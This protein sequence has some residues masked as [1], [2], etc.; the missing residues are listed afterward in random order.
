MHCLYTIGIFPS[1]I[2][3]LIEVMK[4]LNATEVQ[5]RGT[6]QRILNRKY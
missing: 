2:G 4:D 1:E 6:V 3:T 5:F